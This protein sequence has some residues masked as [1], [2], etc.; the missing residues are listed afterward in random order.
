[1]KRITL[2]LHACLFVGILVLGGVLFIFSPKEQVSQ[3]EKRLLTQWPKFL[4]GAV[5]SGAYMKAIDDY[6]ADNFPE[7]ETLIGFAGQIYAWRGWPSDDIQLFTNKDFSER[8]AADATKP[9][10]VTVTASEGS[11]QDKKAARIKAPRT[12]GEVNPAQV[13]TDDPAPQEANNVSARPDDVPYQNIESVIVQKG[14]AVQ[15]YRGNPAMVAPFA[16]VMAQY[17]E[18]FPELTIYFMAIPIGA[19]F[20]LPTKVS[21]GIMQEKIVIDHLNSILP[22][23]IKTVPAYD[24]LMQHKAEYIY[25]NTDHH[26]TALGAYYAYTAFAETAGFQPLELK[27]FTRKEIPRFLGTLYHRTLAPVLKNNPDTV[28]IYKVPV[29]TEV[30]YFYAGLRNGKHTQLYAEYA[31]GA[32]AYGV[33]LGGDYPLMKIASSVKNGR[34]IIVVKDSYGNA[35]VP[36][37]SSHYEEV[38]VI[39]YRY[40]KENIKTLVKNEGVQDLLFAH[41]SYV[42]SNRYTARQERVFLSGLPAAE[43][44]TAPAAV[45]Q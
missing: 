11:S 17:K 19:D 1:M 15:M 34:K 26:W 43:Q 24:M 38:F 8:P 35:F 20:Y 9:A 14:R 42:M 33:F 40:F 44:K 37:L 12:T 10:R 36:Y 23:G 21:K 32:A 39:D 16:R 7:R 5:Q 18:E 13:S 22:V 29:R 25:F 3:G 41:N 2:W 4:W 28:E 27:N 31:R 45:V 6:V 30:S